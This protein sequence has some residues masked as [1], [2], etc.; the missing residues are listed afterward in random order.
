MDKSGYEIIEDNFKGNWM[1]KL[2]LTSI[3][4]KNAADWIWVDKSEENWCDGNMG[5]VRFL[6]SVGSY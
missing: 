2:G 5:M 6:V 3:M 4:G 1:G